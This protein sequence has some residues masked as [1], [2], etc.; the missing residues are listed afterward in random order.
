M[1]LSQHYELNAKLAQWLHTWQA[2]TPS[3]PMLATPQFNISIDSETKNNM[4]A[5]AIVAEVF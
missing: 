5:L 4:L 1:V 3:Q 2:S